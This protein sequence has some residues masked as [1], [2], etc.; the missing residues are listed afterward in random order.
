[1]SQLEF[2]D[3][4]DYRIVLT[5]INTLMG[6]TGTITADYDI[7]SKNRWSMKNR[8][9]YMQSLIRGRAL[10][11]YVLLDIDACY[12]SAVDEGRE[13]DAAYF[14][15]WVDKQ[16]FTD[17]NLD[18][19]NRTNTVRMFKDNQ[20]PIKK[21]I[22][23]TKGGISVT[24]RE[25]TLYRDLPDDLK[26][27]LESIIIPVIYIKSTT[28]SSVSGIFINMND[29]KDMNSAEKRNAETSMIQDIIRKLAEKYES[30]F[31][32]EFYS[33]DETNRRKIDNYIAGYCLN[34][35]KGS[36]TPTPT[37]LTNMVQINSF[38]DVDRE[39]FKKSFD[40]FMGIVTNHI[41]EFNKNV[42]ALLDL[43]AIYSDKLKETFIDD[44]DIKRRWK[45][46]KS[47]KD[48]MVVDFLSVHRELYNDDT[49]YQLG[50]A[51][52]HKTYRRILSSNQKVWN[53]KRRELITETFNVEDY[54]IP[55]DVRRVGTN[56]DKLILAERQGWMTPEGHPIV[57]SRLLTNDY[58][59]GH[60]IPHAQGGTTTRDNMAIQTRQDNLNLGENIIDMSRFDW[61]QVA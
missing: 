17:L 31:Y 51:G 56:E 50:R 43:Y 49:T 29:G 55:L 12:K 59:I 9:N 1:M 15:K 52:D 3:Y 37:Q 23:K 22:Y 44:G 30:I 58:H 35:F 6:K 14:K 5:S 57:R 20:F 33:E 61:Y 60:I 54:M 4:T 34:Y 47:L 28:R 21:G 8:K 18:S 41:P 10:S 36:K 38:A 25:N 46:D 27:H 19:W 26:N 32:P 13:E 11:T 24:L 2:F 16:V 53:D 45:L 39:K 40:V 42:N 7:Q 48:Q